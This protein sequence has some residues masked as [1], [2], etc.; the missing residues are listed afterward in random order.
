M[1]RNFLN[2]P[3]GESFTKQSRAKT[4]DLENP[5]VRAEKDKDKGRV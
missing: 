1:Q 2:M 5:P 4:G 3:R